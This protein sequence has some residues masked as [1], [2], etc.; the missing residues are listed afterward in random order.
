MGLQSIGRKH[1][2]LRTDVRGCLWS[3]NEC[4]CLRRNLVAMKNL[5]LTWLE[6]LCWGLPVD[7]ESANLFLRSVTKEIWQTFLCVNNTPTPNF[8]L[9]S[10]IPFKLSNL[11]KLPWSFFPKSFVSIASFAENCFAFG[12]IFVKVLRDYALPFDLKWI[13][14]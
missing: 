9:I 1:S 7:F 13:Y 12:T 6:F 8:A 5:L 10:R 11:S 3:K 2:P 4:I 14:C